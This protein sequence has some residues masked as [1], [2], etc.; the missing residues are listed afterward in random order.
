MQANTRGS[1]WLSR[2]ISRS[3]WRADTQTFCCREEHCIS[4]GMALWQLVIF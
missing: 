3:Y 2:W 1:S 4:Q